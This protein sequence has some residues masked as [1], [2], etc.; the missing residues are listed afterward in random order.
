MQNKKRYIIAI[1][2]FLFLGLGIFAFAGTPEEEMQEGTGSGNGENVVNPDNGE[3]DNDSN[4]DNVVEPSEENEVDNDSSASRRPVQSVNYYA[5]ALEAVVTSENKYTD[6]KAYEDALDALEDLP[7][8]DS[9][10]EDLVTRLEE[11]KEGL[12]LIALV[13]ELVT[14]VNNSE[15]KEDVDGARG[16]HTNEEGGKTISELVAELT[17]EEL[18]ETLTESLETVMPILNDTTAPEINIPDGAIV[19]SATI[20]VTDDSEFKIYLKTNDEEEKE[21]SNNYEVLEGVHTVRV[22]DASF[23][24]YTITF[25]VDTTAP[26]F[27]YSSG[28]HLGANS[29]IIVT[30]KNFDRVEVYVDNVLDTVYTTNTFTITNDATYKMVAYDKAGNSKTIYVAID[31]TLPDIVT[32][33]EGTYTNE[34]VTVKVYDK[35]LMTV[36]IDGVTYTRNDFEVGARNEYFSFEKLITEEGTHTVTATDKYGNTTTREF[37]IDKH[38]PVYS[39]LRILGG[40]LHKE[41][42]KNVRYAKVGTEV[43]VYTTFNE[44][45][46]VVPT[47]TLNGVVSKSSYLAKN[48]PYIYAAKFVISEEDGLNDGLISVEVT[49]Y[50][51]AAGNVGEK[52]TSENLMAGQDT[53][54]IDKTPVSINVSEGTLGNDPYRKLNVKLFDAN[55]VVSVV[56]NGEKLPHTGKYVDIN[57]GD[58]YTFVEGPNTIVAKDKAGNVTTKVF[59]KDTEAP[60]P[61]SFAMSG[62]NLVKEN[63]T[64]NWYVTNGGYIYVN[65]HFAET[66]A[67]IPKVVLNGQFELTRPTI[68]PSGNIV[69]YSYSYKVKENDGLKDGKVSVEVSEYADAAGNVGMP[70]TNEHISLPSQKN[71]F[72]DKTPATIK[73]QPSS[74]GNNEYS[75]LNVQLFDSYGVASVVI[76]GNKIPHN[77]K[78]V[79]INDGH[80]YRF[81][82][83]ENTIVAR[84]KAGNVT[85]ATFIKDVTAPTINL[86]GT[87]GLKKNEYRVEAGTKVSVEDIMA[88]ATDNYDNDVDIEIVDVIF[89]ATKEHPERNDYDVDYSNG[90][91]TT[92]V[93][94]YNITYKATDNAKNSSTKT[95]L[96]VISDTTAPVITLKGTEGRNNNELRVN[97]DAVVTLDD[98]TATSND[99]VDGEK[100]LYPVSVTRYYP[101]ETGKASHSFDASN[102][103]DTTTPGYYILKYEVTDEAGNYAT[104]NML[105]VVLVT[106]APEVINGVADL[107]GNLTL[108]DEPFYRNTTNEEEVLIDGHGYSVTQVITSTDKM[109]WDGNVP[110]LGDAFSSKNGSKITVKNIKFKGTVNTISLGHYKSSSYTNYNTEFDNVDIIGLKTFSYSSNIAPAVYVLGKADINNSN[111]YGTK[112]SE[113]EDGPYWP[114]YDMAVGNYSTLNINNS[115]IGSLYTWGHSIVNINNSE[116]DRI[117]NRTFWTNNNKGMITIGE[118]STV[119]L[120]DFILNKDKGISNPVDMPY[121]LT[122][123]SGATV[124]VL[125]ISK[126]TN[127]SKIVIEEGAIVEKVITANGEMSYEDYLESKTTYGA[128][129][130]AFKTGGEIKLTEDINL[131]DIVEL[132]KGK[133]L[134]IDLNDKTLTVEGEGSDRLIKNNGSLTFKNGNITQKTLEA[135]GLVENNGV[136][137]FDDIN[138]VDNG[139]YNNDTI[140]NGSNGEVFITNSIIEQNATYGVFAS[141]SKCKTRYCANAVVNS[142]GKLTIKDTTIKSNSQWAYTVNIYGGNA[143]IENV[144]IN[145]GR[146][147][148]GIDGGNVNLKNVDVTLADNTNAYYAVYTTGAANVSITGGTMYSKRQTLAIYGG[149]NV[150]VNSGTFKTRGYKGSLTAI[151]SDS[152]LTIKGG[153]FAGYDAS[154]YLAPG[155]TQLS[156]GEVTLITE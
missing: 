96:L 92:T 11:V 19:Q 31:T 106:K 132:A 113:L 140:I 98:V 79:D 57:D 145:S 30:D 38:A 89:L 155:Y 51:D 99:I 95:M 46:A 48:G 118:G 15:S 90:F 47:V 129:K 147:G 133:E 64:V 83:G 152:T 42:G 93:G 121:S 114:I 59:I 73:V 54:I 60:V 103:F 21:I 58:A 130:V 24:E 135:Y 5:L 13:E 84:D 44:K 156:S 78:Y 150:T 17:N 80:A 97:Q 105:L 70:L 61:S 120:V 69:I 6:T 82:E 94:R 75:K 16:F 104:K 26:E 154:S 116:V 4:S 49:G 136:L 76:N 115:K 77:G 25:E 50:A 117:D 27:N 142:N 91:D 124:K 125:D 40:N 74:I 29:E 143:N 55:E 128:F 37:I 108:V 66:L 9:R 101:G 127:T 63:G 56:I 151:V 138:L 141:D 1:A 12:D 7:N 32:G 119:G 137:K 146:G 123:K 126:I 122:V 10:K 134:V 85:T 100:T 110:L 62:G 43:Y 109:G 86:K 34:D 65:L 148:F 18:K 39:T 81:T 53:V 149:A 33:V 8:S 72:V 102:G 3:N 144:V 88:S 14:M 139:S 22:V 153:M 112:R 28:T 20:I 107:Y 41:N 2:L 67:V 68:K 35:F 87:L 111:I 36:V 23:N 71:V 45:L 131:V 52:L